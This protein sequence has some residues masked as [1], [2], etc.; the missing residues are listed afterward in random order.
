MTRAH[1]KCTPCLTTTLCLSPLL[2]SCG[3]NDSAANSSPASP[4][5]DA[6]PAPLTADLIPIIVSQGSTAFA[7]CQQSGAFISGIVDPIFGNRDRGCN[8]SDSYE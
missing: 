6:P 7:G 5:L 4:A 2:C 1:Q 3:A 8:A